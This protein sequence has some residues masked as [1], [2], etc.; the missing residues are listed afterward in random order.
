M[1]AILIGYIKTLTFVALRRIFLLS[2]LLYDFLVALKRLLWFCYF[3]GYFRVQLLKHTAMRFGINCI[4]TIRTNV[5]QTKSL[6]NYR[7]KHSKLHIWSFEISSSKFL[8]SYNLPREVSTHKIC[9]RDVVDCISVVKNSE[10]DLC[11]NGRWAELKK[12]IMKYLIGCFSHDITSREIVTDNR[13]AT[14]CTLMYYFS[15]HLQYL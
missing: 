11:A 5:W 9:T 14:H 3:I 7:Y 15:D 10:R 13:L 1:L 6:C 8:T 2:F 12:K 4:P